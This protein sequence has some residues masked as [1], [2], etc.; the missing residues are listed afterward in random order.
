M[1][2]ATSAAPRLRAAKLETCWCSV[3]TSA[4]CA[5]DSTGALSAPGMRSSANSEGE[6]TSRIASN[7]RS[8][9]S[10][11][12]QSIAPGRGDAGSDVIAY[13]LPQ[14]SSR[15]SLRLRN[16]QRPQMR[17]DIGQYL[18]LRLRCRMDA[19]GLEQV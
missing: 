3:P 8:D 7:S 9:A 11:R 10:A 6:R 19:I 16:K 18:R 17:P 12:S 4:R 2:R 15:L 5:S 13:D 1:L 14:L